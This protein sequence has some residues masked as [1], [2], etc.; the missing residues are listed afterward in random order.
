MQK[1]LSGGYRCVTPVASCA[2]LRD[3]APFPSHDSSMCN[4]NKCNMTAAYLL[5]HGSCECHFVIVTCTKH[6]F[7]YHLSKWANRF[8]CH[9]NKWANR[10]NRH[11]S[12]WANRFNCHASKWTDRFRS[13]YQRDDESNESLGPYQL[14]LENQAC[15]EMK[16][17]GKWLESDQKAHPP[18]KSLKSVQS[19]CACVACVSAEDQCTRSCRVAAANTC[20]WWR[21]NNPAVYKYVSV[22]VIHVESFAELH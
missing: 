16:H 1:L 13:R 11:V 3:S 17:V 12:K 9:V 18:H 6:R 5:S 21:T 19:A 4:F 10:F 22:R 8:N 14:F 7:N 20:E 15:E 2:I